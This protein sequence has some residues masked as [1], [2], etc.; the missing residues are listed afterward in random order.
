MKPNKISIR[1]HTVFPSCITKKPYTPLS[2]VRVGKW[3]TISTESIQ[4]MVL[5]LQYSPHQPWKSC[6]C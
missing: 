1:V 2:H 4:A 3:V 5:Q 6:V